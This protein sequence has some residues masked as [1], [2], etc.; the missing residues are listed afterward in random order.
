MR[1]VQLRE[2]AVTHTCTHTHLIDVL[3]S[4]RTGKREVMTERD[5]RDRI[6]LVS[7]PDT[8]ASTENTHE[9]VRFN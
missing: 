5:R 6:R 3:Q 1:G 2:A 7:D 4:R 9:P 8:V